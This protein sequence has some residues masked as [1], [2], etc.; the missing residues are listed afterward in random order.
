[1]IV[2]RVQPRDDS[3]FILASNALGV[4]EAILRDYAAHGDSL[5]L[6]ILIHIVRQQFSH[7]WNMSWPNGEISTVLEAASK[8]NVQ[9]TLPGLQHEFCA[10]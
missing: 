2:A 6:A 7:F 1:M 10:L 5:S 9:D 4:P 3:W 8:F